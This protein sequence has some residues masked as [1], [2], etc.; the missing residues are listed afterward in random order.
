MANQVCVRTKSQQQPAAKHMGRWEE[1]SNISHCSSIVGN[2]GLKMKLHSGKGG[3][4]VC[5]IGSPIWN[6]Y[7]SCLSWKR[8]SPVIAKTSADPEM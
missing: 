2:E 4:S 3:S 7:A 8:K 1:D 5:S 6:F